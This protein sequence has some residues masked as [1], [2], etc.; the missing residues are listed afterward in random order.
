[1]GYVIKHLVCGQFKFVCG[2]S[3]SSLLSRDLGVS[4]EQLIVLIDREDSFN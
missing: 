4:I 1:M 2:A 3:S